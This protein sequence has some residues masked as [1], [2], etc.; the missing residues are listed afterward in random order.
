M[1]TKPAPR[2]IVTRSTVDQRQ[3]HRYGAAMGLPR[4]SNHRLLIVALAITVIGFA[5]SPLAHA[6]DPQDQRPFW[7][8]TP[9]GGFLQECVGQVVAFQAYGLIP[10][11]STYTETRYSSGGT[12]NNALTRSAGMIEATAQS[13]SPEGIQCDS[14][15]RQNTSSS[16]WNVTATA[17]NCQY[18]STSFIRGVSRY[19]NINAGFPQRSVYAP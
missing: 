12:C 3:P 16:A 11:R 8:G 2:P 10:A 15:F 5:L 9:T 6:I 13:Y 7:T 14:Q 1:L 18:S 19:D 17:A 4:R